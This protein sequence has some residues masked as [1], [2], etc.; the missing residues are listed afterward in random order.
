MKTMT[1]TVYD[2]VTETCQ[3][4]VYDT[5][6]DR[7]TVQDVRRTTEV[8]YRQEEFSYQ[9]PVYSTVSE[10]VPYT[11]CRPY[12]ETLTREVNCVRYLP[13]YE[14]RT[15]SVPY[16]V[17]QTVQ[18]H[19]TRTVT[20]RVPRQECYTKT[21]PV[22]SGHWETRTYEC[23][24]PVPPCG[25]GCGQKEGASQKCDVECPPIKVC[26]RVWVPCVVQKEVTCTRTV[27][28]CHNVEIP[29]TR[30]RSVPETQTREVQYTVCRMVP[31]SET[32][33][34]PYQVMRTTTEQHFRTVCRTV[35]NMVPE[36]G[37]RCVPYTETHEIPCT[38]E[39]CVPRQ[40]PRTVCFTVTRCVP[41]TECYQVPVRIC[42]PVE[43]PCDPKCG[44]GKAD[45]D[46]DKAQEGPSP[47]DPK[48]AENASD[49]TARTA[50]AS[51]F[52][53]AS[54]DTNSVNTA[55]QAAQFT[56]GIEHYRNGRFQEAAELFRVAMSAEPSNAKYAYL[57]A[58]ALH[59]AGAAD[60]AAGV[61]QQAVAAEKQ[62]PVQDWGRAMERVQG[63]TRVWLEQQRKA[64]NS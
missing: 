30:C 24:P 49:S 3:K 53:V 23:R 50:D 22:M 17:Y 39:V 28:D 57:C 4:V 37:T 32:R 45:N 19:G 59:R 21:V 54:H 2:R 51:T 16:T 42:V 40:V 1:R 6:Y 61:L 48:K 41:R 31:V 20:C 12:Y 63:S 55:A 26:K 43:D 13:S 38:R 56:A 15:R 11:V 8:R 25:A 29:Y 10:Q 27:Y 44:K 9:R 62:S 34:V 14:T 47:P 52:R 33:T 18:E 35:T 7:Q 46:P 36:V 58:A 5:V 64:I 60:Q